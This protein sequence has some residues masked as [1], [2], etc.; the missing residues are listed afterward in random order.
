M[1]VLTVTLNAAVDKRYDVAGIGI[2]QVQRVT[3]VLAS[4][5][6]KGLNVARGATLCG[7]QAIATG[8]VAGFT[9]EFITAGIAAEGVQPEFITVAGE[10]RT[11]IN[12]VDPDGHSTEF[13]EPGVTVTADDLERLQQRFTELLDH[14][15]V[16]TLS[17]SAPAGCA[18]DVYQPLIRAAVQRGLPVILDTSAALLAA[19]LL[20]A[21]TVVKPNREELAALVGA[22]LPDLDAIVAAANLLRQRGPRWVVVSLGAEGALAVGPGEVVEVRA[23]KVELVNAVGCGDV[24]VGGLATGLATGLSVPQALELGVRVSAAAAAH[25]ATGTFDPAY[26]DTLTTTA[27]VYEGTS[28]SVNEES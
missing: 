28:N 16:V 5:G 13:L 6:G 26:A 19:G 14:A 24:L 21:P 25:P 18:E 12:I 2:G 1:T 10:S 11:C 3:R 15:E 4:A 23:P 8:F 20:A 9:G 17:G 22:D 7:Q 27:V